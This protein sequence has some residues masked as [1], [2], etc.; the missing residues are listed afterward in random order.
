MLCT[1]KSCYR[2]KDVPDCLETLRV[3]TTL[4]N[5][6][7][8]LRFRAWNGREYPVRKDSDAEGI[9]TVVLQGES[10]DLPTNILNPFAGV[11]I[12]IIE[13]FQ[14]ADCTPKNYPCV[15]FKVRD[16]FDTETDYL[17]DLTDCTTAGIADYAA[18]DYS[19]EFNI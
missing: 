14:Y 13:N 7:M 2:L 11:F 18:S 3:K 12:L 5:A 6:A 19:Q 9:V 10:K 15:S 4:V 16:T 8:V 17:M 1:L